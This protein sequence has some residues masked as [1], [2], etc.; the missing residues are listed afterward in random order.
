MDSSETRNLIA[1]MVGGDLSESDQ[2][3]AE[4]LVAENE[5]CRKYHDELVE[6]QKQLTSLAAV[7]ETE[8]PGL[9]ND[10][11]A[12]VRLANEFKPA[13]RSNK[14][15]AALCTAALVMA[16]V[17]ISKDLV[18]PTYDTPSFNTTP[19]QTNWSAGGPGKKPSV[20]P[21]KDEKRKNARETRLDQIR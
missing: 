18:F 3:K 15:V 21:E 2:A 16:A 10:I 11:Q 1:L 19:M 5:S 12:D 14:W 8:S 4:Q 7:A 20:D 13:K 17:G 9:W 6:S